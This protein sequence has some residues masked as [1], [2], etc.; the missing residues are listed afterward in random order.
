MYMNRLLFLI[1]LLFFSKISLLFGTGSTYCPEITGDQDTLEKQILYNGR[2]WRNLYSRIEGNP[3][4]FTNEFFS[5]TVTVNGKTFGNIK[6]RYDIFNDQIQ[7]LTDKIIIL[8]LNKEMVDGFTIKYAEVN[9]AFKKIDKNDITPVSGF[10]NVVYDKAT[11]LFVKYRK[12]IDTSGSDN[13][14]GIF[15]LIRRIYVMKD[16]T[17]QQVGSRNDLLK[18]LQDKKLQVRNFIRENKIK[19]S[20]LNP[21]SFATVLQFYDNIK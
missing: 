3:F 18:L 14:Y 5:G 12:E 20:K 16:G 7:I 21:W 17:I 11:A 9:Y 10:V 1:F 2:V 6:I 15:Y 8:Q 4:I 19:V 13:L